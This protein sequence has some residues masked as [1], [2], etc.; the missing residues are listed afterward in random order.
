MNGDDDQRHCKFKLFK[1]IEKVDRISILH[2]WGMNKYW[3][4]QTLVS[5]IPDNLNDQ[6]S[7][8]LGQVVI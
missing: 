5:I 2:D 3:I 4:L 6:D 7:C 8:N 1:M